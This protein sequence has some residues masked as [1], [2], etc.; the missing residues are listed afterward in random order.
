MKYFLSI[1]LFLVLFLNESQSQELNTIK[2]TYSKELYSKLDTSKSK[3]FKREITKFNNLLNNYSKKIKYDL[4]IDDYHSIF[5]EINFQTIGKSNEFEKV[6]SDI[7]GTKGEFYVNRKDSIFYNKKHFGGEDFLVKIKLRKWK[8]TNEFKFIRNFKCFKA[9][10]EDIISNPSGNF[11]FK[12]IAWFCPKL[13]SFFGPASYFG[14]PGL[15]LEL[16][17]GKLKLKANKVEI[18]KIKNKKVK[19]SF[20]YIT[21]TS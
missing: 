12:V 5:S 2:V 16:D 18:T 13:P 7:G 8:I 19:T 14:L 21:F 11:K 3:S 9:L 15:V 17:N 4:I 6:V 20:F 10:S 1:I